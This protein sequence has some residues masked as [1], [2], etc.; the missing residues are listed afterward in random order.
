MPVG[1]VQIRRMVIEDVHQVMNVE[2]AAFT[3]PWTPQ[4]FYNELL[5]NHFAH[6]IV[7]MVDQ[8][9]VGYCGT[10]VIIDEAHITN[11][12]VHP[13]YHGRKIGH[14]LMQEMMNISRYYGANKMTLEVRASNLIAQALYHKLGFKKHG[15]RQ[16]YYT[17]NNEDAII[18]WVN[19]NETA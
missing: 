5:N 9:V 16:G 8:R 14:T 18:M 15:I 2:H 10:W 3:T 12:A 6:Y 13:D 4:A 1:E 17:D 19:L 11:V 7:A